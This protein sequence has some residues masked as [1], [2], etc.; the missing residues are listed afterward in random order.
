MYVL[1]QRDIVNKQKKKRR[2]FTA[3]CLGILVVADSLGAWIIVTED[4]IAG[5]EAT[6]VPILGIVVGQSN[7][8]HNKSAN[9]HGR[10]T[11]NI[12]YLVPGTLEQGR[13]ATGGGC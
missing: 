2:A 4:H 8:G 9:S 5:L 7:S 10:S 3:F 1:R 11:D 6:I 12:G 13:R